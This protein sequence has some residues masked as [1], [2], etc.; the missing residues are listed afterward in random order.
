MS[1]LGLAWILSLFIAVGVNTN[2]NAAFALQW[3]FAFFNSLQGFFVS[4]SLLSLALMLAIHG[5]HSCAHVSNP[6]R[7]LQ[8]NLICD[9]TGKL[10]HAKGSILSSNEYSSL[11]LKSGIQKEELFPKRAE[12]GHS[13]I[14]EKERDRDSSPELATVETALNVKVVTEMQKVLEKTQQGFVEHTKCEEG[15]VVK[16]TMRCVST[17]RPGRPITLKLLK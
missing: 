2:R 12:V 7:H 15:K 1:L 3:M 9:Y 17:K 11:P 4:S 8:V 10:S 5:W 16:F 14:D 6:H 13:V